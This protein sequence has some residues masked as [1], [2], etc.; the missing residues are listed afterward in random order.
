MADLYPN[1]AALAAAE[2][3]GTDYERRVV[4]VPGATW[5]S[6]AVH[7]GG[8]EA[9]SGELA[10]AVGDGLMDHYEFAG[11][12][13]SNNTSLHITSTNFDEP[14][15]EA[16]VTGATRC[17]S[18]HGYAGD[19]GVP[20][21]AIGGLDESLV[22]RVQDSL[23]RAGFA[24][25][26][27]PSEIAGTNPDNIC[28]RTLV[29]AGVQLELSRAQRE[30]FFPDGDL[31][32]A[33]RDSG[34]R[35]DAFHAYTSAVRAAFQGAGMISLGSVNISRYCLLPAISPDV[36][37]TATLS[38]DKLAEG[39]SQYLSLVA[40]YVDGSNLYMGRLEFS[41][42]RNVVLSIRRRLAGTET[43]LS[44]LTT[45]LTHAPGR[46]FHIRLQT[47]GATLRAKAWQVDTPEPAQWQITASDTSFTAAGQLGMRSILSPSTTNTPVTVA[48]H[49][50]SDDA[51]RSQT[52]TV[53]RSVNGVVKPH[54]AATPISLAHPAIASL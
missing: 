3:E 40:R 35:T 29:G 11:L 16:M 22:T 21:T 28:N 44:Q 31:R 9:G 46:R 17:L 34:A 38:T 36:D 20:M 53:E 32:R 54:P 12:K 8:I 37:L 43:A 49:A 23:E 27:A 14:M 45:G 19:S 25:T 41:T 10:R 42:G 50:F 13:S 1:Y 48:W 52:L 47:E 5:C 33:M 15:A 6:I 51:T 7:G 26:T 24:V 2:T 18:F 39:G 30:A 4:S